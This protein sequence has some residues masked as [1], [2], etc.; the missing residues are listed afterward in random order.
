MTHPPSTGTRAARRRQRGMAL[1]TMLLVMLVLTLLG[2]AAA[3]TAST[4]ADIAGNGRQE[5]NA[6][7]VAEAGIHEAIARLNIKTGNDPCGGTP[8]PR[9]IPG[10]DGGGNPVAT[11][12]RTIVATGGACASGTFQTTTGAAGGAATL[13]VTTIVRYKL[14]APETPISHCDAD[15]C[16]GEVVR[17]HTGFGYAGTMVPKSTQIGP[18]VLELVSTY[19][20][21]GSGATRAITVEMTRSISQANTPGTLRS[22]G[23]VSLTGSNTTD[24]NDHPDQ[25]PVYAAGTVTKTGAAN[26]TPSANVKQNQGACPGDLFDQ[27]FGMSKTD[28]K[29]LADIHLNAGAAA[30]SGG[31]ANGKIVWISGAG[32]TT[33]NGNPTVGSPT[34]PVIVIVEGN[35]NVNGTI[36][37]Y[38]V[39]Y[40]MGTL[41][42]GNGNWNMNG[43]VV[44]EGNANVSVAG[45]STI[46][47]D[48]TV[49]NS[50]NKL[51]P[52]TTIL[53]KTT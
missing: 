22:C 33:W 2:A 6:L 21:P 16:N 25:V 30:P 35:M 17:F 10:V 5:L 48:P 27:T 29:A 34:E 37:I 36:T 41:T 15:G 28:L 1:P 7:S 3:L 8:T 11:W 20:E 19:T 26:P 44:S 52:F 51:S 45:N 53:W 38:G 43:A 23:N 12:E 40:V 32:T 47:Y 24:G 42:M 50:V 14:E 39:L 4:D 49:M 13:P 31:S 9:I 46:R 18:P